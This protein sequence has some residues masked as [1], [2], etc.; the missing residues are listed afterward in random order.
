[1]FALSNLVDSD[2]QHLELFGWFPLLNK[3]QST[4]LN[5][6]SSVTIRGTTLSA[7]LAKTIANSNSIA[8]LVLG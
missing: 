8:S 6:Y 5:F 4:V 3:Y 2:S 1:M 7:V